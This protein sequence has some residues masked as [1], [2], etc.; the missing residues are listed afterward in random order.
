MNLF[1]LPFDWDNYDG[2]EIKLG[3]VKCDTAYC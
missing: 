2:L 1:P 3:I